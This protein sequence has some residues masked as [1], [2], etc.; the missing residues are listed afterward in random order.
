MKVNRG[1]YNFS[2]ED[3]IASSFETC[4]S[5]YQKL[6]LHTV[7]QKVLARLHRIVMKV[8]THTIQT[9]VFGRS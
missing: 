4:E 2:L 7:A 5:L 6:H 8:S 9:L 3:V 1:L